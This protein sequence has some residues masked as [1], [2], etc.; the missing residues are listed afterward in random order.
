M[1]AWAVMRNA[2]VWTKEF[3]AVMYN[4]CSFLQYDY[5]F[6]KKKSFKG[7]R[8]TLWIEIT[9][10][11]DCA[12]S[13]FFYRIIDNSVREIFSRSSRFKRDTK[14][15]TAARWRGGLILSPQIDWLTAAFSVECSTCFACILSCCEVIDL[16][17]VICKVYQPISSQG[18][19][20]EHN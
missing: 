9:S 17:R 12:T 8:S 19:L 13:V 18:G 4:I 6:Y 20:K 14:A 1:T 10:P 5:K 3:S 16:V 11:I 2:L 7:A 15:V